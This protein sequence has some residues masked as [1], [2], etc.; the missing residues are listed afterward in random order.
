MQSV[1]S[2]YLVKLLDSAAKQADCSGDTQIF[3]VRLR[4]RRARQGKENVAVRTRWQG[5]RC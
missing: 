5:E 3:L 1:F 4:H 2:W